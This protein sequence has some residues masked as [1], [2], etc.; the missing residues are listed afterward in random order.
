M[1]P[2]LFFRFP[3]FF[4]VSAFT[5]R[6]DSTYAVSPC[7]RCTKVLTKLKRNNAARTKDGLCLINTEDIGRYMSPLCRRIHSIVDE[8][9]R[10]YSA[11][12]MT[13]RTTATVV[14]STGLCYMLASSPTSTLFC[15]LGAVHAFI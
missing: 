5:I 3:S 7:V 15:Y 1:E 12:F 14:D 10:S 8:L 4:S 2:D 9:L 6:S 13:S 11:L